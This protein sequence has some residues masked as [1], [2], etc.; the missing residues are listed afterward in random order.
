MKIFRFRI[1]AA[2]QKCIRLWL[3]TI[4]TL[5]LPIAIAWAGWEIQS[6]ISESSL[7]KDYVAIAVGVLSSTDEKQDRAL[8]KWAVEVLEKNSPVGFSTE[9]KGSLEDGTT[10]LGSKSIWIP[11]PQA[12]DQLKFN[13]APFRPN[14]QQWAPGTMI[15]S[16]TPD[17][18]MP[19][20]PSREPNFNVEPP[21][22]DQNS[23]ELD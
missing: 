17:I 13:Q 4:G 12:G 19:V 7:K 1:S 9:V 10:T 15:P 18:T 21:K 2:D 16:E 5:L 23:D 8:R 20:A 3:R 22:Q 11:A 6:E 14:G